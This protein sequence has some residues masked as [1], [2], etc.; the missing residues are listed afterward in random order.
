MSRTLQ[1]RAQ[2]LTGSLP[3]SV[4]TFLPRILR[5]NGDRPTCSHARLE[6][7][8]KAPLNTTA[9]AN[10]LRTASNEFDTS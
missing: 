5:R 6:N 8:S 3:Y 1:A 9:E 2:P 4:R 10:K 7:Y